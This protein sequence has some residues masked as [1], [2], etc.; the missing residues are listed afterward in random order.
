MADA[1]CGPSNA[2]QNFQ[3]HS[4][5]D[6]TLQ[7]DRL[8]NRHSASQGFRSSPGPSAG[9]LDPEFD[10]FQAG[11]VGPPLPDFHHL[12]PHLA[13]PPPQHQFAQAPQGPDW[14]SDFQRLNITPLHSAPIQQH[15]LP[16]PP[17][18][19][20]SWH[21]DFMRQQ[22]PAA[23][24][25]AF[26]QRTFG[27]LPGYGLGGLA[28]SALQQGPAFG[29]ANGSEMAQGNQR[30]QEAGLVLDDAAF[31]QAFA[32]AQQDMLEET[33]AQQATHE[34]VL[35]QQDTLEE[36]YAQ[37]RFAEEQWILGSHETN[38]IGFYATLKMRQAIEGGRVTEALAYQAR[39]E[40]MERNG[41]WIPGEAE[42]VVHLLRKLVIRDAPPTMKERVESLIRA[43]NE[44]LM[45]TYPLHIPAAPV[46]QESNRTHPSEQMEQQQQQPL[47]Q[48]EEPFQLNDDDMADTAGRLLERVADNTSEKFQNSQ[49]L[50]L[51]RRLRDR[52]VRVEGDKMVDVD[53]GPSTSSLSEPAAP[54]I[55][56]NILDYAALD[57]DIPMGSEQVYD[58]PGQILDDPVTDEISDQFRN[59]N[60]HGTYHR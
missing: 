12:P 52:E 20:A 22:S 1:L 56:P 36:E 23:Q 32:Q 60:V 54:G 17:S 29:M 2:L 34:E 30:A 18:A 38:S 27:R 39:L 4:S 53:T 24:A 10:A 28:G 48:E 11:H 58:L 9:A 33:S 19:A 21:Q 5:A 8:T 7:Q 59:Y 35:A 43:I 6:R 15:R 16:Q 41:Q 3:K 49:F 42:S 47:N 25:P 46:S 13:R 31:E 50:E 55:D 40:E 37:Q 44:R 45:S 14:A 51:M 57:F 26:Q